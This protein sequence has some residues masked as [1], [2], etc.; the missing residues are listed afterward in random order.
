MIWIIS[1]FAAAYVLIWLFFLFSILKLRKKRKSILFNKEEPTFS[2]IVAAR[3]EEKTL[4]L[5][6]DSLIHQHISW[7]K[8][9]IIIALNNC[10]DESEK[11]VKQYSERYPFIRYFH[12]EISDSKLSP[13]KM[14]LIKAIEMSKGEIVLQTDADC[15]LP[16]NW[17]QGHITAH[18]VNPEVYAVYGLYKIRPN[19]TLVG[20]WLHTDRFF[21]FM[22]SS[23][24]GAWGKPILIFGANVSYKIKKDFHIPLLKKHIKILSGDDDILIQELVKSGEKV[25]FLS[26]MSYYPVTRMPESIE[27]LFIQRKRHLKTGEFYSARAKWFYGIYILSWTAILFSLVYGLPGIVLLLTKT[28]LDYF[29][30]QM[31]KEKLSFA[32]SVFDLLIYELTYPLYVWV[33]GLFS[34][35]SGSSWK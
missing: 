10:S 28:L 6:L 7:D 20:K 25:Y 8:G 15:L 26:E 4:P 11:I 19:D 22:I 1:L 9:E 18:M 13:K 23:S 29:L 27:E 31:F 17:I 16:S 5:L 3:N 34:R 21:T 2:V 30:Y 24:F 12:E 33:T 14:A 32:L 35:L